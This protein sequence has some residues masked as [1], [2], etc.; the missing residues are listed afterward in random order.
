M[1]EE[2]KQAQV[3]RMTNERHSKSG[4]GYTTKGFSWLWALVT[5][6]Y[7]QI[8]RVDNNKDAVRRAQRLL[9]EHN[10]F[11]AKMKV[12]TYALTMPGYD[13]MTTAEKLALTQRIIREAKD[14]HIPYNDMV[15]MMPAL[16]LAL[17]HNSRAQ[18]TMSFDLKDRGI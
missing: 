18:C 8:P 12:E 14:A 2:L 15:A 11:V 3:A 13:N 16:Q 9:K 6:D 4:D 5:R 7:D 17:S 10:E 1:R